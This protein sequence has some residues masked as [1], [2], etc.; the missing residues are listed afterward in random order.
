MAWKKIRDIWPAS[1]Q[2]I[3]CFQLSGQVGP[4][5]SQLWRFA[6]LC[7]LRAYDRPVKQFCSRWE[8]GGVEFKD[9]IWT[10]RSWH[11]VSLKASP[12]LP[13]APNLK[14]GSCSKSVPLTES[15][16]C[17][18]VFKKSCFPFS[19]VLLQLETCPEFWI[20]PPDFRFLST[21]I[22]GFVFARPISMSQT[23][24]LPSRE[25]LCLKMYSLSLPYRNGEW[26]TELMRSLKEKIQG[27]K[28]RAPTPAYWVKIK[29]WSSMFL[30]VNSTNLWTYHSHTNQHTSADLI[31]LVTAWES[32]MVPDER[33][34]GRPELAELS[35]CVYPILTPE[36]LCF[37]F[38]IS[39][40]CMKL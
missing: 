14:K 29:V 18:W 35:V 33:D 32:R 9:L 34:D 25:I 38:Y 36:Q 5:L 2:L 16:P 11:H 13:L 30:S 31:V 7:P 27:E 24:F 20:L 15:L 39:W 22:P 6:W 17:T 1:S 40:F 4:G 21:W 12:P 26:S 37:C 3:T 19:L 10:S 28:Q 8:W 23:L